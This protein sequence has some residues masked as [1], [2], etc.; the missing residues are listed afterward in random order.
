[1]SLL[2]LCENAIADTFEFVMANGYSY[3]KYKPTTSLIW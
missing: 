2:Y 3:V 1:M